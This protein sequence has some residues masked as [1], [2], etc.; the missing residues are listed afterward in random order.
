LSIW[1]AP[2]LLLPIGLAYWARA[3]FQNE[4]VFDGMLL[5]AAIIGGIFY[6]VGLDSAVSAAEN[7]R[8]S[9]LLELSRSDGPLSIT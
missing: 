6:K 7:R 1:S 3:V 4:L 9:I 8:E 5:M 2:V